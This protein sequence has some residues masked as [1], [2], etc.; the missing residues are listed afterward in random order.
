VRR[1]AALIVLIVA[2]FSPATEIE[3]VFPRAGTTH[4]QKDEA[5]LVLPG[6]GSYQTQESGAAPATTG[7]VIIISFF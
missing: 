1:I 2:C 6:I 3:Y 4:N 7:Q 5:V